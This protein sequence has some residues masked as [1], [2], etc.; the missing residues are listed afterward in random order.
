MKKNIIIPILIVSFLLIISKNVLAEDCPYSLSFAGRFIPFVSGDAGD[1]DGAPG[2]KDA[3]KSG[4]SVA[5]EVAYRINPKVSILGGIGYEYHSGDE[6][7]GISF[8]SFEILPVYLGCKYYFNST[9]A[10]WNPYLRA[11]IG[12]AGFN[13]VDISYLGFSS[14][15]WDSSWEPM[16]DAGMGIEYKFNN[17]A[18]SAEIKT[19]YL[20]KPSSAPALEDFSKADSSWSIPIT[21]SLTFFF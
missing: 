2:Y 13:S 18:V 16:F 4:A 11:D 6:Y 17:I 8:D 1:G 5:V 3:F 15:Y 21:L 9:G 12:I 7:K 14:E 19:R 10:G 20:D